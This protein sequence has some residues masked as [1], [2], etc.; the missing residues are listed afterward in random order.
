VLVP[1]LVFCQPTPEFRATTRCGPNTPPAGDRAPR[2]FGQPCLG[3]IAAR[4][5]IARYVTK[6]PRTERAQLYGAAQQR[7]PQHTPVGHD[8]T[9][10]EQYPAADCQR[11]KQIPQSRVLGAFVQGVTV[12][13]GANS[14]A[15]VKVLPKYLVA[16]I[17]APVASDVASDISIAEFALISL[18]P[19]NRDN[20]HGRQSGM[21]DPARRFLAARELAKLGPETGMLAGNQVLRL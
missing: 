7:T 2:H 17:S 21:P 9:E 8:A 6:Q 12:D 14:A 15:K 1:P 4:P 16:S 13:G 18:L 19:P 10:D 11:E 5:N 3:A 20:A